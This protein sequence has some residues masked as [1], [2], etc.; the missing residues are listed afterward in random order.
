MVDGKHVEK[1]ELS[2]RAVSAA[3]TALGA[4]QGSFK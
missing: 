3:G 1:A 4:E 2:R